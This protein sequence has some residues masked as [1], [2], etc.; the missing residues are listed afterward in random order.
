[1]EIIN[2]TTIASVEIAEVR[3]S[4]DELQ[5]YETALTNSLEKMSEA[6]ILSIF[7]A[8]KDELEGM[9]DDVR[10]VLAKCGKSEKILAL[11]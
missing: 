3:V 11:S 7:G 2:Q 5:V 4:S 8:S 6:E 10:G 9:R 1:M